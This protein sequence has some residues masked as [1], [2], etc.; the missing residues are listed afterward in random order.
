MDPIR[1]IID[2]V[3][4]TLE[5]TPPELSAD[6]VDKGIIL[7]GGGALLKGLTSILS[8]ETMLP[9]RAAANALDCVVL[10]AGLL[11]EEIETLKIINNDQRK[12]RNYRR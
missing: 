11:L 10:G 2:A 12:M 8:K 5:T 9:V 6:I 3:K 4:E 7:T 1:I